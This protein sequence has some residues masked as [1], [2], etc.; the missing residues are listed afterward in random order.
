MSS[1]TPWLEAARDTRLAWHEALFGGH[2]LRNVTAG[3]STALV[4]IPLNVALALACQLP[5]SVGLWTGAVA[6][7]LGAVFGSS[8]LQVTGPEI[9]LA[10]LTMAIVVEHGLTGLLWCT[11]LAGAMQ[12]G[13]GLLRVGRLVHQIP[14]PVIVGFLV[15]I[16]LLVLDSQAPR[17]LGLSETYGFAHELRDARWLGE[18]G[19]GPVALGAVVVV[20]FWAIPRLSPRAPAALLAVGAAVALAAALG[21]DA[22]RVPSAASSGPALGLPDAELAGVLTLLP[23]ALALCLLASLS[24]LLSAAGMDTRVGGQHR[25][26][27]ELVAHGLANMTCGLVGGM[28]V[29]GSFVASTAAADAGGTSRVAPLTQ[30]AVLGVALLLLGPHLDQIPLAVL[31][32][33]LV[34]VAASLIQPRALLRLRRGSPG[35]FAVVVATTLGILA[36]GVVIGVVLGVSA[37]LVRLAAIH[38]K[39]SVRRVPLEAGGSVAAFRLEGPL[40][41][42]NAR[43]T[44]DALEAADARTVLV[45]LALVPTLDVSAIDALHQ[46]VERLH[47][48]DRR[49]V[50]CGARPSLERALRAS[51]LADDADDV[52]V[53]RPLT[54]VIREHARIAHHER[55]DRALAPLF[56][57]IAR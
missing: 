35:D 39:V 30:A 57:S 34:G 31:A 52:D 19:V 28:P 42:G 15:A 56:E 27:Q 46:L 3:I 38:A 26:D 53:T 36:F 5:A 4:A 13:L 41:F 1:L 24:S 20:L 48:E 8:K 12:V 7:L 43:V 2:A 32:A 33:L 22:P 18:V 40:H 37:A 49:L 45:D 14:L 16:G 11:F 44:A 23:T 25:S 10:P 9:A 54:E 55:D 17:V 29:A 50:F 51:A 47:T 21:V 6:G